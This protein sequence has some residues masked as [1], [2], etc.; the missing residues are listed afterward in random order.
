MK[1]FEEAFERA[2]A[3][4]WN[5]LRKRDLLFLSKSSGAKII[6]EDKLS[7]RFFSDEVEV[8][9]RL[10]DIKLKNA[11]LSKR[12]RVLILHYLLGERKREKEKE[13]TFL[14]IP[15]GRFYYD[16]FLKR[17]KDPILSIFLEDPGKIL[18][19]FLKLGGEKAGY[20]DI[21]YEIRPFPYV[22]IVYVFWAGD[23]E[24]GSDLNIIFGSWTKDMLKAYDIVVLCELVA[25]RLRYI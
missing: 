17:A 9:Q 11:E 19:G 25:K 23:E 22:R 13:I 24:F 20:G 14:D 21:S 15:D 12:E 4:A 3:I 8:N 16:I 6:G 1:G 18:D 5:E 7:L 10:K 2:E